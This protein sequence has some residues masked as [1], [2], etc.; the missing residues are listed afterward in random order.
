MNVD[1]CRNTA[2][3]VTKFAHVMMG[4]MKDLD[5]LQKEVADKAGWQ[6]SRVSKVLSGNGPNLTIDTMFRLCEALKVRMVI[7]YVPE[8]KDN[9]FV[10]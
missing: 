2:S 5:I 9:I 4:R 8:E 6:P 10:N 1:Y 7:N 3:A